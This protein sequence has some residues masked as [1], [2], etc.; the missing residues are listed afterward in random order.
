MRDNAVDGKT[1]GGK[2]RFVF[3]DDVVFLIFRIVKIVGK[4]GQFPAV[5]F[6]LLDRKVKKR[7]VVGLE[8]KNSVGRENF[9]VQLK[10]IFVRKAA[11]SVLFLRPRVGKIQI[12]ARKLAVG[13]NIGQAFRVNIRKQNV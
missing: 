12:N 1:F 11:R 13:K 2:G 7:T 3:G 6:H 4:I 8:I 10:K 5:F 9:A